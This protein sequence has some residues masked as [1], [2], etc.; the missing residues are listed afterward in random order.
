MYIKHDG[1]ESRPLTIKRVGESDPFD[2]IVRMIEI[3]LK[4]LTIK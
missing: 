2:N 3:N 1:S 4:E